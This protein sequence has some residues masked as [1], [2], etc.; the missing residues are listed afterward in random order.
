MAESM[1]ALALRTACSDRND[2]EWISG[3]RKETNQILF[4]VV[5]DVEDKICKMLLKPRP[6][7]ECFLCISDTYAKHKSNSELIPIMVNQAKRLVT[8][9]MSDS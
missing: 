9:H 3:P 2:R 8:Q 1:K 7:R 5:L 6:D 4:L